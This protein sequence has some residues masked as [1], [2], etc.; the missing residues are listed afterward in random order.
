M[1]EH[2]HPQEGDPGAGT[3]ER[4][5]SAPPVSASGASPSWRQTR[6]STVASAT[7]GGRAGAAAAAVRWSAATNS[8]LPS[9]RASPR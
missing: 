7:R 9:T 8:G 6:V 2:R 4:G 5:P 1:A 3:L